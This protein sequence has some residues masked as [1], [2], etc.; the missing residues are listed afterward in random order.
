MYRVF[1]CKSF[2][3][4]HTNV[5]RRGLAASASDLTYKDFPFLKKLGIEENN[6]GVFNGKWCGSGNVVTSMNPDSGKPVAN[7]IEGS[8]K[9]YEETMERVQEAR[10]IWIR[11][12]A[13][14]R[15]EVVRQIGVKL[16]EILDPLG[17]LVSLEMGK[18]VPEGIGEVQEY[19]D[20]CDFA[21]G[22]SRA[23][24]G[25]VIPSERPGHA[26]LEMW[27]P[28]GNVGIIS[29]FNF[30]VAVYGWNNAL[31]LVCGNTCVWK[32]APTTPL[33]SIA[34]TKAVQEVFEANN[35]PP[36][37][38]SLVSGGAEIGNL[39]AEDKR[40]HLLSFT[41]S[42]ST[43]RQ[44]AQKVQHRFGKSI[45]ELGGNNAIIVNEDADV[46]LASR[47]CLFAAVGT[48]GQRCTTTRR[49]FVHEKIYE[50]FV[51]R[52]LQGYKQVRIGSPLQDGTLCGPLHTAAAVETYRKTIEEAKAQGGKV[53]AGG[54]VLS[55]RPGHYVEP[56]IIEIDPT[57]KVVLTEAFVPILYVA[58][59]KDLD[60]AI[61]LNNNVSQGLSSS[62]FTSSPG[63]IFK[64]L[65]PEGADS[66]IVNINIPTNGA[67]IGGAFGGEKETGGGR[68]SGS[69]SWKQYMRRSTCTINY[70]K[71][72]PLA[73]GIKFE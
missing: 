42:T 17:R 22:L 47:A 60:E 26:M 52:L 31:S 73:Q 12:T 71:E 67:E 56:T 27:N 61:Q 44:V 69:D 16:R 57:A 63:N 53:L 18:I 38:C 66:G 41:G 39:M 28:L 36:E 48:A 72:L 20:I 46:T 23:L 7:V 64:Y 19:V 2:L 11:Q 30:P 33:T 45:L 4:A 13:P 9:D 14:A 35:L 43:G 3:A 55:E 21:T 58:K 8:A 49:L 65:G 40:I 51:E 32:G 37:I 29:A 25:Q 1:Q 59:F 10:K 62:L 54:R 15:G 24:N 5:F 6:H 70:S 50:N 68:E 34:V